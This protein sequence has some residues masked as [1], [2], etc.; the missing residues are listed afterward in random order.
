VVERAGVLAQ[1]PKLLQQLL[2]K[3]ETQNKQELFVNP[4]GRIYRYQAGEFAIS[5]SGIRTLL[6]EGQSTQ[7]VLPSKVRAYIDRYQLF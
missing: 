5:S 2:D 3:H 1:M 7:G 4:C 6:H